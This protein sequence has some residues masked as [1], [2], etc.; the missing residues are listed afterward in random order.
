MNFTRTFLPLIVSLALVTYVFAGPHGGRQHD[1]RTQSGPGFSSD[2]NPGSLGRM[3]K[4][5]RADFFNSDNN[6]GKVGSEFGRTTAGQVKP[7]GLLRTNDHVSTDFAPMSL[8][9]HPNRPG[10]QPK[11]IPSATPGGNHPPP[12]PSPIPSATPG[13]NHPSP[14]PHPFGTPGWV[15]IP[16]PVPTDSTTAQQTGIEIRKALP[17][18][19][20]D[21]N[22]A[23]STPSATPVTGVM[24]ELG[25]NDLVGGGQVTAEVTKQ[26][27]V[28]KAAAP[29]GA[30][31]GGD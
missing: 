6:P 15:T 22:A 28:F 31:P 2:N 20:V 3:A 24:A 19:P 26:L 11:P 23:P 21:S 10:R 5:D 17:V 25:P 7:N 1:R 13:G 29:P 16:T 12:T 30:A 9:G 18:V 14:P 27:P 8:G 4:E